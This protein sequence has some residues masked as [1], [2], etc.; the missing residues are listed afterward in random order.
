MEKEIII[1]T[2]EDIERYLKDE[3]PKK[4]NAEPVEVVSCESL[5][6]KF[7]HIKT[8]SGREKE[9]RESLQKLF[10]DNNIDCILYVSDRDVDVNVI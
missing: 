2:K 6:K 10:L 5:H 1:P 7:M 4:K 3:N 9:V 8:S